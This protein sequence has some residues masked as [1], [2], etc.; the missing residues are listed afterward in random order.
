LIA[1]RLL[2]GVSPRSTAGLA[3][4][5]ARRGG[6]AGLL[7]AAGLSE[8]GAGAA[9]RSCHW[10]R[11]LA[12]RHHTAP[13]RR[14]P[15]PQRRPQAGRRRPRSL[16]IKPQASRESAGVSRSGTTPGA[17]RGAKNAQAQLGR[18][19]QPPG[20]TRS[21]RE[22]VGH[23]LSWNGQGGAQ[24]AALCASVTDKAIRPPLAA[25]WTLPVDSI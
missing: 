16:Q 21:P 8:D 18:R 2:L 23:G 3:G 22:V 1:A 25:I 20:V 4:G 14:L 5:A 6:G 13:P 9:T 24:R 17:E 11:W 10:E 12:G 7:V 15:T 19:D